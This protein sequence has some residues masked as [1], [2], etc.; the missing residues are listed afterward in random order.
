MRSAVEVPCDIKPGLIERAKEIY[1]NSPFY[2]QTIWKHVSF[3]AMLA[4][5][6]ASHELGGNGS[7]AY[8][9]GLLHDVGAALRGPEDHHITG[10]IIAEG[11]LR[12]L[13]YSEAVIREVL[14]C[15]FVHRGS[16]ESRR[17]TIE[18]QCVASADGLAHFLQIPALF[19][20]ALFN[21]G[22]SSREAAEWVRNK[23]DRSWQKMLPVHRGLQG[24]KG[25][26][27]DI[28]KRYQS[29]M[30]I[31]GEPLTW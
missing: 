25:S 9:G 29:A 14:H 7:I 18:A 17:E 21:K 5:S 12:E 27:T 11:M 16:I 24:R 13:G 22:F 15:I 3:V 1:L 28:K 26:M 20:I 6:T 23:L 30:D 2:D 4:S 10:A 19:R 31:L 8:I